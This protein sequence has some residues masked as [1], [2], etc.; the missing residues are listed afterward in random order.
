MSKTLTKEEILYRQ[1]FLSCCGFYKEKLDGDWGEKTDEAERDF[2][3]MCRK[4]ADEEGKLDERTERNLLSLQCE[5]QRAARRSVKAIRN[6]GIDARIISATRTYPEQNALFRQ[7]RFGNPGP[8]VTNAKAGQ[9]WHNFGLAWDVGIFENG[10]YVPDDVRP[11]K[12]AA[13]HGKVDGVEWGGDWKTFK[14]FPHYQFG[15]GGKGVSTARKTFEA[16]GR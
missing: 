14:D 5:A 9:S 8:V 11:Y 1:Q 4:I 10:K 3:S 15:T 7:G 12:A 16:G 2:F 13:Q 6:A